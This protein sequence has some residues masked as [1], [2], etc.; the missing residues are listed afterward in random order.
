[1]TSLLCVAIPLMSPLL[2]VAIPLMTFLRWEEGLTTWQQLHEEGRSGE[3]QGGVAD[4][5]A[6]ARREAVSLALNALREGAF[7]ERFLAGRN[8]LELVEAM[9]AMWREAERSVANKA[10]GGDSP[11]EGG[12]SSGTGIGRAGGNDDYDSI[13]G[14]GRERGSGEGR[15]RGGVRVSNGKSKCTVA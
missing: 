13:G 14:G 9:N 3:E 8:E 6:S 2:C 11:G 15:G 1:M 10:D 12:E 4:Q 7:V 5:W